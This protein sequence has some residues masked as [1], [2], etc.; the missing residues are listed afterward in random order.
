MVTLPKQFVS[1]FYP[2]YFW[3][4]ETKTLFTLKGVG[5]LRQL[6]MPNPNRF[7]HYFSGY[8]ISHEGYPRKVSMDYLNALD[9]LVKNIGSDSVIPMIKP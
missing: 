3:N 5:V 8:V 4:T 2:G 7:N 6:K 1:I 9:D